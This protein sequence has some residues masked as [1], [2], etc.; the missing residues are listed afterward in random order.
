LWDMFMSEKNDDWV[1]K[2]EHR[3]R[4]L[5]GRLFRIRY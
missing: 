5:D 2:Q 1:Y 4:V 3:P